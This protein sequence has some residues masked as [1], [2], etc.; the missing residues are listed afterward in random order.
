MSRDTRTCLPTARRLCRQQSNRVHHRSG[1]KDVPIDSEQSFMSTI[2]HQ[3]MS[4][5]V[6]TD[7]S[8]SQPSLET[9]TSPRFNRTRRVKTMTPPLQKGTS[10]Q[11]KGRDVRLDLS[12][13]CASLMMQY[14]QSSCIVATLEVARQGR[15]SL[16]PPL[17]HRADS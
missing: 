11:T 17:G 9:E 1:Y 12:T 4:I 16:F 3:T 5:T 13:T 14:S 7:H 15:L 8:S 2:A 10:P 6:E